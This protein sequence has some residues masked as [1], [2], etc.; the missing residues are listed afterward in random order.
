MFRIA[1]PAFAGYPKGLVAVLPDLTARYGT[2][3]EFCAIRRIARG[4]EGSLPTLSNAMMGRLSRANRPLLGEDR[5]L[6]GLDGS[7][8][9]KFASVALVNLS[10][11]DANPSWRGTAADARKMRLATAREVSDVSKARCLG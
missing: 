6:Y 8:G 3:T 1:R 9:A 5:W 4:G 10:L 2:G 7:P 11:D